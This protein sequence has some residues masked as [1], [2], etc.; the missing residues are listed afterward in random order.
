MVLNVLYCTV[1]CAIDYH[2]YQKNHIAPNL[3][4][5]KIC[6]EGQKQVS[7]ITF[8][9]DTWGLIP[10]DFGQQPEDWY[11]FLLLQKNVKKVAKCSLSLTYA[12]LQLIP[13]DSVSQSDDDDIWTGDNYYYY[14]SQSEQILD[15]E[16]HSLDCMDDCPGYNNNFDS[17][18]TTGMITISLSQPQPQP[19]LQL[20]LL[21][22]QLPRKQLQLLT[23]LP[24]HR[25]HMV[26]AKGVDR[27]CDFLVDIYTLCDTYSC[28]TDRCVVPECARDCSDEVSCNLKITA[29]PYH[30]SLSYLLHPY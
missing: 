8:Y 13:V 19:Q 6:D 23:S 20:L 26:F 15:F 29:P 12:N 22:L 4:V 14:Y 17:A 30:C 25:N 9:S 16:R 1:Y 5:A 27:L 11:H 10:D 18:M 3:K 24:I 2:A 7:H 28:G 21:L